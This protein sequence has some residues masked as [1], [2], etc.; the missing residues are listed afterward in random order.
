MHFFLKQLSNRGFV[1]QS[2]FNL[3][4]VD[5]KE[6]IKA[7]IGFD[8]TAPSLHVGSLIQLMALRHLVQSGG[9]AVVLLGEATTRI[10]DPSG[11]SKERQMLSEKEIAKN[12]LGIERAIKAIVPETKIVSNAQW[13]NEDGPSFMRFLT[14]FGPHFSIKRMMGFESVK[15]RM[16][17]EDKTLS[18]LEFSYMLLQA[19]DFL[20]LHR[21]E[22]VMMQIGGS[23]QWGNMVNGL[24]LI[25]RVDESEARALTTPLLLDSSGNQM[26]KSQGKPVWLD[27]DLTSPFDFFQFWRNV[28]DADVVRFLKLFTEQPPEWC[29]RSNDAATLNKAKKDL[30]FLVTEIVHGNQAAS[31]ALERSTKIFEEGRADVAAVQATVTES[32][33]VSVIFEAGLSESKGAAKRLLKQNAV[34]L[35][36]QKV[37]D[38]ET[39]VKSGMVLKVGK[40][41]PVEIKVS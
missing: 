9:E 5:E 38:P 7:Y 18:F 10:G 22:G 27:A 1:H 17:D 21:H 8:L 23:D 14:E 34:S 16:D 40:Q 25:R 41:A 26:G 4:E 29:E 35:D 11:K 32:N 13:F 37:T 3:D 31:E 33:L 24:E 6:T 19:V 2:S 12:F 30:A 20:E 28:D 39:I 15:S 36:G